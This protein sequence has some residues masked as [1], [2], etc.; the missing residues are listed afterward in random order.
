MVVAGFFIALNLTPSPENNLPLTLK[1]YY[2]TSVENSLK[3]SKK[4]WS[5]CLCNLH[6]INN[7]QGC[8]LIGAYLGMKRALVSF[9]KGIFCKPIGHLFKAKRASL[10]NEDVK[11]YYIYD[12]KLLWRQWKIHI[13]FSALCERISVVNIV[14]R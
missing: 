2:K 6:R 8:F 4:Y 10:Q 11:N 9:Q 13:F 5:W 12:N 14:K 1:N 7:L 3:S